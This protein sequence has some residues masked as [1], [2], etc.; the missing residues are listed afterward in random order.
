MNL[1]SPSSCFKAVPLS[2]S[3]FI[4]PFFLTPAHL[5]T[6]V[7]FP[8]PTEHFL[9]PY[10][11]H[12]GLFTCL[13]FHTFWKSSLSSISLPNP[14]NLASAPIQTETTFLNAN[15]CQMQRPFLCTLLLR[16]S[17][18]WY[19]CP[20]SPWQVISSPYFGNTASC[21]LPIFLTTS[22]NPLL[23]LPTAP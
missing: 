16:L 2:R 10:C 8:D 9:Q 5:Q 13:H 14:W 3:W 23:P 11:L 17:V 15:Y 1:F 22:Q 21:L 7:G 18:A 12:M 19:G 6:C 4:T 20:T